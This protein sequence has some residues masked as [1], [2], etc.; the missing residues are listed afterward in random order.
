MNNEL[1]KGVT[2]TNVLGE[3]PS[4]EKFKIPA[5][6]RFFSFVITGTAGGHSIKLINYK[7]SPADT[8]IRIK[9]TNPNPTN[10]VTLLIKFSS[11]YASTNWSSGGSTARLYQRLLYSSSFFDGQY[12]SGTTFED[13]IIESADCDAGKELSEL[14]TDLGIY[15][16]KGSGDS[17]TF[18]IDNKVLGRP[19]VETICER[20]FRTEGKIIIPSNMIVSIP[21]ATAYPGAKLTEIL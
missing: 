21:S 5:G 6:Y 7:D 12:S 13:S 10:D 11:K 1:L 17:M 19:A 9:Q 14:K 3:M 18:T 16:G 4:K 20:E 15:T 2:G 8:L